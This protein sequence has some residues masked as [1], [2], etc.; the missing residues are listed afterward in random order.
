VA[1]I[2]AG[3]PEPLEQYVSAAEG[4]AVAA[5]DCCVAQGGAQERFADS[6]GAEDECVVSGVDEPERAQL[7]EDLMVVV[8]FGAAVPVLQG[9][10]RVEP[11]ASGPEAGG[12]GLSAGDFVGE[13]QLEELVVGQAA[14]FGQ[15]EP[16]GQG[17]EAAAEFE[18]PQQGLQL[19][20]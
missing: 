19:R 6:D 11:G 4:D 18:C 10:V 17:V 12:A 1:V 15:G 13:D 14:L 2:E 8:D 16:F 3:R 20:W 7:V 9:H 5:A